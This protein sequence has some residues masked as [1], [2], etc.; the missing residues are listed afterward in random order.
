MKNTN[1]KLIIIGGLFLLFFSCQSNPSS[2]FKNSLTFY[3]S[4][5]NGTTADYALGS[6]SKKTT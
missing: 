5:D 3:V 6:V 1:I 2:D 4:F